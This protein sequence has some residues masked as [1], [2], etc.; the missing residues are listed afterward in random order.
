MDGSAN[1]RAMRTGRTV[2]LARRFA[3]PLAAACLLAAVLAAAVILLAPADGGASVAALP[4]VELAPRGSEAGESP[5]GAES[6]AGVDG[7]GLT[8]PTVTT[9]MLPAGTSG[10]TTV[11]TTAVSRPPSGAGSFGNGSSASPSV[12]G[13]STASTAGG[14]R[15][16]VEGELRVEP[17]SEGGDGSGPRHQG[18]SGTGGGTDGSTGAGTSPGTSAGPG[19]GTGAGH[20]S[21]DGGTEDTYKGR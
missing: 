4:F 3:V 18:G 15:Q 1:I 2:S 20:G 17:G 12:T 21:G 9:V 10:G 6:T 8:Q 19:T 14:G 16:V 5:A 13:P 11:V 7:S